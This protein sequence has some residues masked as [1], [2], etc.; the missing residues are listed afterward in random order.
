M[1]LK[2]RIRLK[3]KWFSSKSQYILDSFPLKAFFF[4]V[5]VYKLQGWES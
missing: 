2:I 5:T 4:A 1:I 3:N